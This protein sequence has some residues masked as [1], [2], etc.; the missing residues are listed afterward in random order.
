MFTRMI[1]ARIPSARE[2]RNQLIFLVSALM[3]TVGSGLC[4]QGYVQAYLLQSGLSSASIGLYGS[5]SQIASVAAYLLFAF[6]QPKGGYL[7]GYITGRVL[8]AFYPLLLLSA[9]IFAGNV[10][11]MLGAMCLAAS[12]SGF[13]NARAFACLNCMVTML[14]P[15]KDYG[16]LQGRS[17][18][19]AGILT[20]VLS[21]IAGALLSRI[22]AR[23][24]YICFFTAGTVLFLLSALLAPMYRLSSPLE[25]KGTSE[26]KEKAKIQWN[27]QLFYQMFPHFLRGIGEAGCYYFIYVSLQRITLSPLENS[28]L[29][30]VAVSGN[31]LGC[32]I[33][34]RAIRMDVKT[35]KVVQYGI[36]LSSAMLLVTTLNSNHLI[37]FA[38]YFLQQVA[39]T[40]VGQLVPV[41]VVR[42]TRTEDLPIIT[43]FRMVLINAANSTCTFLY[44]QLFPFL[45]AV[46]MMGF[47]AAAYCIAGIFFRRQFTDWAG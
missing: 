43:P 28:L 17:G 38:V 44:G 32:L 26:K 30:S 46:C 5:L 8:Y 34:T 13:T 47:S 12:I 18:I 42:S 14:F 45:P 20:T 11:L 41:G 4:A 24:G 1:G 9:G 19:I 16:L 6:H 3:Q 15:R 29:V 27:R 37:F 40:I 7:G 35:G 39:A 33:F 25:E 10:P 36:L 31:V 21:M 2:G 22:E 23:L